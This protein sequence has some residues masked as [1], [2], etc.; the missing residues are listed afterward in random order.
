MNAVDLLERKTREH[1]AH[2]SA[3]FTIPQK[4]P[5]SPFHSTTPPA[6]DHTVTFLVSG[7]S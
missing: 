5:K 7:D 6:A 1:A 4:M 3:A 2:L